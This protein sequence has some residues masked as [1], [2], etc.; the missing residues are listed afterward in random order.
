MEKTRQ[1]YFADVFQH[2]NDTVNCRHL[3]YQVSKVENY[4]AIQG[5]GRG[6]AQYS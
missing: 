1:K 4:W 6:L 2:C 3:K 5:L